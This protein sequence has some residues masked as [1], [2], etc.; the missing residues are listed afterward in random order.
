MNIINKLFLLIAVL[1][2]LSAFLYAGTERSEMSDGFIKTV[3]SR[4]KQAEVPL[5]FPEP[6][7]DMPEFFERKQV[8]SENIKEDSV[9]TEINGFRLQIFKTEDLEE[10]KKRESMYISDFGEENIALIFEKPFYKIRAGRFRNKEEAGKFQEL[11]ERRGISNTIIIPDRVKLL[12][13]AD[14]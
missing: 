10:A 3:F 14:N 1:F 12:M 5:P 8:Y 11:L 7:K 4:E 2:V 9:L 13:P 6:K